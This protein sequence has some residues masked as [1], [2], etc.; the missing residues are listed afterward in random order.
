MAG[1]WNG[2]AKAVYGLWGGQEIG[3]VRKVAIE[4][5]NMVLFEPASFEMIWI[6]IHYTGRYL[7]L[8]PSREFEKWLQWFWLQGLAE[9]RGAV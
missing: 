3:G 7:L 2:H 6:S 8:T 4:R 5:R 9:S 1:V